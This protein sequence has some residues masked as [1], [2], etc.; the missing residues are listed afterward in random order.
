MFLHQA[1]EQQA[2]VY[3]MLVN[4]QQLVLIFHKNEC[5]EQCAENLHGLPD[6]RK[7]RADLFRCFLLFPGSDRAFRLT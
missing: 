3:C 7:N 6:L 4:Q 1:V 2:F 5:V